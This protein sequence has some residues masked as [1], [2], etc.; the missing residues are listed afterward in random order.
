MKLPGKWS[1]TGRALEGTVLDISRTGFYLQADVAGLQV[2]QQGQLEIP[3]RRR[4]LSLPG[5]VVWLNPAELHGKP[6]GFGAQF[7]RAQK[8]LIR[9]I[10]EQSHPGG[11]PG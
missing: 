4:S 10:E 6:V 3:V 7:Q 8:S 9:T 1:F 11:A 2:G 5:T